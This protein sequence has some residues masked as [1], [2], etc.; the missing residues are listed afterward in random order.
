MD[1]MP[2]GSSQY[3]LADPRGGGREI[4]VFTHRPAAYS[5]DGAVVI[6]MHGRNRNGADYR[7]WW[8]ASAEHHGALVIVPEFSERHYAHPDDYNYGGMFDR[9][10]RLQARSRWLYPV[11][12]HIFLDACA[13]AGGRAERYFLFGHS[14]GGQLVHRMVT[15]GWS[16]RIERAVAANSGSYAMPSLGEPFPFGL[17]GTA[18]GVAELRALL[19]R[20][21]LV[22]LGEADDDPEHFQLPREPGAMR[23]GAHRLARGRHYFE[24]GKSEAARLGVEFGWK[25]AT[26]PG[27]AH[28][29]ELMSPAAARLLFAAAE[30]P[31]E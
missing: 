11:I 31:A 29:G 30:L 20:P 15:F 25:I 9:E 22:L 18:F 12:D 17:K 16:D 2:P 7:N 5:P 28:S 3:V 10:G 1:V 21:L 13:R 27:V 26:V 8:V 6:V 23:Q 14:A 4:T 19:A 24:A